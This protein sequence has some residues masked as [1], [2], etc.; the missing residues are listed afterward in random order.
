MMKNMTD[1]IWKNE[2][3]NDHIVKNNGIL[4]DFEGNHIDYGPVY[5]K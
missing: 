3:G 4:E 5:Y 2:D 1:H